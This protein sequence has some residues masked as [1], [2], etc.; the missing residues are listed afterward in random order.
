MA[1]FY[2][3]IISFQF[4]RVTDD[5]IRSEFG[6]MTVFSLG[7]WSWLDFLSL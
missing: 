4:E 6:G 1:M 2:F 5:F 3:V 7:D